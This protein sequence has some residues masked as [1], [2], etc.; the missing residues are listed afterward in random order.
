VTPSLPKWVE[1]R[2]G[3][4]EPFDA[5]KISQGLYAATEGAGASNAFLA[6]ELADGVLHFLGQENEAESISAAQIGELVEK[7]V[8]ELGN[9][10]L[11]QA[12]AEHRQTIDLAA[13]QPKR[14]EGT[15][16][17]S[18]DHDFEKVQQKFSAH[19]SRHAVFARDLAAA[20][21]WGLITLSGE[22]DRPDSLDALVLPPPE[23]QDSWSSRSPAW[24]QVEKACRLGQWREGC[25]VHLVR[26]LAVDSADRL[27]ARYGMRW[28]EDLAAAVS[29][30]RC[31]VSLNL[32]TPTA[33]AWADPIAAGPLFGPA[34]APDEQGSSEAVTAILSTLGNTDAF[35]WDVHWHLQAA[36]FENAQRRTPLEPLLAQP[37]KLTWLVFNLH[38]VRRPVMLGQCLDRDHPAVLQRV[39]LPLL[40]FLHRPECGGDGA[41]MIDKL[42]SLVRMA[43][44]AGVQKRNYL[45]RHRTE[46][47]REFLLDRAQ[48]VIELV[49]LEDTIATVGGTVPSKSKLAL[50]FGR[51][52]LQTIH[53]AATD[54]GKAAN[55]DT[56]V[57]NSANLLWV[58]DL[59]DEREPEAAWKAV[60]ALLESGDCGVIRV[61]LK[62]ASAENVWRHLRLAWRATGVSQVQFSV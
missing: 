1:K 14:H 57:T 42:P 20:H 59:R 39:Y 30:K 52:L 26:W 53:D 34:H 51:R 61:R 29:A 60:G 15:F 35:G 22:L 33:P 10:E 36:D 40:A 2:D 16:T 31:W 41:K 46:L 27:V 43:V 28:L 21:F 12:F 38:R 58:D 9:P 56:V 19:Y 8:R 62:K 47:S 18:L 6:R 24:R 37:E 49:G 44:R 23:V 7:V 50:D 3:R 32:N 4:R 17:Y 45:R 54:A 5:D 11:A 25:P 48:L 55:L 13:N